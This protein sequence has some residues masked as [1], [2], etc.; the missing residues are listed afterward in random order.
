MRILFLDAYYKPEKIAFTHLEE[1]L[2]EGFVNAGHEIDIICPIPTRGINK[3]IAKKYKNVKYEEEY[4]GKVRIHR[5]W[6]PQEGINPLIRAFRYGWCNIRTYQI[7]KKFKYIDTIFANS[8]P[9]TQGWVASKLKIKL[10]CRFVYSLQDIF[11]DS[12]VSTQLSKKNT[13]IYQFGEKIANF[14]YDTADS[15]VVISQTF[16]NNI[17]KKGVSE[18]KVKIIYNWVDT[19]KVKPV[20]KK[21]NKLF[22]ELGISRDIPTIVYAGNFGASQ[23]GQIIIDA[24][25]KMR[26]DEV[27]FVFF[28]GGSE[29]FT[30]KKQAE[31]LSNIYCFDLMPLNRVSEVY[32]LGD[33]ALI[34]NAPGVGD[35]GMP[36]KLW[37]IMA[38]NTTIVASIDRKSELAEVIISHTNGYVT[39]AGDV[40]ELVRVMR[41]VL[42][43]NLNGNSD[44]A[45]EYTKKC[46]DKES[47]VAKYLEC[48]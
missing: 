5:F 6:A 35:C 27:Q 2:I 21:D 8:T 26:N 43:S 31:K 20:C 15:I 38:T 28:G 32:S 40:Q 30:I 47:A 29:Y 7:G 3:N 39:S 17:I 42:K 45:R 37:M 24:A 33:I 22:D 12:L 14:T 41:Y 34:T 4:D 13:L 10:K 25:K 23:N 46:A 11:P 19:T 36:S 1:D 18:S 16:K 9:P 44:I 48:L